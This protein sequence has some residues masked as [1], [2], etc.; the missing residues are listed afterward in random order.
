VYCDELQR[1]REKAEAEDE[2][3]ASVAMTLSDASAPNPFDCASDD[4]VPDLES[5]D[6]VM[7]ESHLEGFTS[8]ES[9]DITLLP[10]NRRRRRSSDSVEMEV[11]R[12]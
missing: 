10:P 2:A 3:S 12:L 6:L 1:E 7:T 4:E 8:E 9:E 11:T 5:E